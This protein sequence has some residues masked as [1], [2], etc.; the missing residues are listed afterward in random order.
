MISMD[1]VVSSTGSV[2]RELMTGTLGKISSSGSPMLPSKFFLLVSF[3]SFHALTRFN[4]PR[5][6]AGMAG[7]DSEGEGD[8]D[9]EDDESEDGAKEID[10]ESE[11][12]RPK[13]KSKSKK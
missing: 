3:L 4:L 1:L 8:S 6:A 11:D 7:D 5:Y 12:E 2:R 13:K 9:D 10:L